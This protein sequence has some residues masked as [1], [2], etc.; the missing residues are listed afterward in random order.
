MVLNGLFNRIRILMAHVHPLEMEI[1][2]DH[3]GFHGLFMG[4]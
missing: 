3:D 4:F 1:F 2:I